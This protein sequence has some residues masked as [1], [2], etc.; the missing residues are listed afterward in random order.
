MPKPVTV[1]QLF[2]WLHKPAIVASD[3]LVALDSW[4]LRTV[5]DKIRSDGEVGQTL[6]TQMQSG[7]LR[8]LCP[9]MASLRNTDPVAGTVC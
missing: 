2:E 7:Q 4:A 3:D 5:E 9:S 1:Q 8:T 6:A